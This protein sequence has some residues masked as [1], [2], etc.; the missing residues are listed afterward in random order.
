MKL[1]R[2]QK[3]AQNRRWRIRR[4]VR[5][6]AA[7]PRLTVHFSHKHVYA[8]CI[9]DDAAATLVYASSLDK[10]GAGAKPNIAGATAL[11][12]KV[13][14]LAREKGIEAVVFDRAGRLY[15][16]CVKAFAESARENGLTF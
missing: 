15:H 16:G 14:E 10:N 11:G 4:K 1:E 6:T 3:L 8:Q 2:K 12:A 9:D 5:G 13:A 7:R